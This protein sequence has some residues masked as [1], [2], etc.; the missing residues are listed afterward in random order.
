MGNSRKFKLIVLGVMCFSML[1]NPISV[2]AKGKTYYGNY[3]V[4]GGIMCYGT[5]V[6]YVEISYTDR[7]TC[8][9]RKKVG[10]VQNTNNYPATKGFAISRNT[11]RTYSASGALPEKIMKDIKL[12][13]GGS[14]SYSYGLQLN[15]S[16]KVPANTTAPVYLR[17]DTEIETWTYT[18]QKQQQNIR[19]KW[20]NVGKPYR[21]TV[22][23]KTVVPTLII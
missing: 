6:K 1:L 21:K 7:E 19:G 18:C 9:K 17:Y 12:T 16:A 4:T 3:G 8:G 23:V 2:I 10:K 15:A 5:R 20:Y 14:L 11:T 13:V 22:T